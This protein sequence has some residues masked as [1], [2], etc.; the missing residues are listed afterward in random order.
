M[1]GRALHILAVITAAL[2]V[3]SVLRRAAVRA[4]AAVAERRT[5]VK[6][7]RRCKIASLSLAAVAV[8]GAV[9]ISAAGAAARAVQ[10]A[11]ERV[12]LGPQGHTKDS[13]LV[14]D[15]AAGEAGKPSGAVAVRAARPTLVMMA[16]KVTMERSALAATE[17]SRLKA[18][19]PAAEVAAVTTE[20]VAAVQAP[21]GTSPMPGGAAAAVARPTLSQARK[22]PPQPAERL[23]LETV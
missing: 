6:A 11:A 21:T 18:P 15:A 16:S 13:H 22:M 7:A 12:T 4:A 2:Q 5:C 1:E 20:A 14:A 9:V 17:L 8:A 23:R 10:S 3:G 19:T